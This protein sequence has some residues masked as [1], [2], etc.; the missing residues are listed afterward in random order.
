MFFDN[1]SVQHY[2]S[3]LTEETHYYP[4]GLTMAEI[5]AKAY[6]IL[7]NRNRY[8]G[9]EQTTELDL[10]QY[11]AFY[12]TLDPQIGRF[13]QI[14]PKLESTESWSP[15]TAMLDNP[16]R[17]SDPLGDS[18]IK[19]AGFWRNLLEGAKDGGKST[20]S[21]VKSL[22]TVEGWKNVGRG[23][24][25]LGER[26]SPGVNGVIKNA[27]TGQTIINYVSNIPN[28]TSDEIG[29]DLGY[30]GEKLL[31]GV[32]LT[33]GTGVVG[34]VIKKAG[35]IIKTGIFAG[36]GTN[37][38]LGVSEYLDDFAQSVKGSTWQTWGTKDFPSQF[39][40]TINNSANKI[41]FNLD[42]VTSPWGAVSEGAKGY[43]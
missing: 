29:H 10:N 22:G 1:L 32:V 7:E 27:Q 39:L 16:I 4:F 31:E 33:K 43:G 12:R 35:D 19:G 17:Y 3:P 34:N 40:E 8:N 5:S 20:I 25:D 6:G 21:F 14:D 13:S 26:M 37:I 15:Y 38:A 28:M 9:I 23:I 30:G 11:D 36:K 42:G 41:H 18:V 24:K 2:T